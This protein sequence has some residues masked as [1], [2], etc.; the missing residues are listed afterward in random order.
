MIES[1]WA[2]NYNALTNILYLFK[3]N[4]WIILLAVSMLASIILRLKE[5]VDTSVNEEQNII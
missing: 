3:S 1:F 5:E 4:L 2:F